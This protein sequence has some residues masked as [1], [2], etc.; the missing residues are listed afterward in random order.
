MV[1]SRN[2]TFIV[3]TVGYLFAANMILNGIW[4][5][6]FVQEKRSM[7]ILAWFVNVGL[8]YTCVSIMMVSCRAEL[9][10]FEAIVIRSG[11]S[12]YSGW[13]TAAVVLNTFFVIKSWKHP[14]VAADDFKA[15]KEEEDLKET[16]LGVKTLYLVTL[17]YIALS[18]EELNPL[19]GLI[20][21]WVLKAI[22]VNQQKN[23]PIAN[24][25]S[26][27]L[28][29]YLPIWIGILGYSIYQK[30]EGNKRGLF[31]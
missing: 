22:N 1:P 11:F 3:E 21:F 25:T 18:L 7:F 4:L 5:I 23:E 20:L 10:M 19:Y 15:V 17:I 30:M 16:S 28:K 6:V 29:A 9:S 31:M 27:L 8:L 26:F 2:N 13:V 24:T 12:I 14:D